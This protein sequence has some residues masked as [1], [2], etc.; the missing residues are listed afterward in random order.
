[1]APDPHLASGDGCLRLGMVCRRSE[2]KFDESTS[3]H[4]ISDLR[5]DLGSSDWGLVGPWTAEKEKEFLRASKGYGTRIT[6][7]ICGAL[8]YIVHRYIIGMDG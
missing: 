3:W 4:R 2:S 1:M 5:P 7:K 6:Q 8:A